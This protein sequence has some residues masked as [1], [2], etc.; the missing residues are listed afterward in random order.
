LRR[1]FCGSSSSGPR[2]LL[3]VLALAACPATASA[4]WF[5]TPFAGFKFAGESR[6]VDPELGASNTK[7][8]LGGIVG[9][10]GDGIL[11]LEADV[12]YSPRFFERSS[13]TLVA[14][15]H[16]LTIMGN[17]VLTTPLE[18]TGDSLRPFISGGAGLMHAEIDDV[19]GV[20]EVSSNLFGINVGGG[21]TGRLTDMTSLR[22]ELRYFK[23]VT[24]E[25]EDR[26]SLG[27]SLS[28]WRAGVGLTVRY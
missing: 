19:A 11:G 17:V 13:G 7:F 4:D 1:L 20:F 28:F 9:M 18:V 5:L 8:T 26:T 6:I 27:T 10:I 16:V 22:F 15:S 2:V 14:R 23:S 25:D 24:I 3:L 12:G 21:A